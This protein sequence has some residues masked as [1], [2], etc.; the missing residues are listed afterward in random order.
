M[1]DYNWC[2]GVVNKLLE[3]NGA[4]RV[5]L[6]FLNK[7]QQDLVFLLQFSSKGFYFFKKLA[8]SKLF[9]EAYELNSNMINW[10]AVREWSWEQF[11]TCFVENEAF[12]DM[13]PAESN[14]LTKWFSAIIIKDA[15]P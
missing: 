3:S 14:L 11:F 15:A 1:Y 5:F 8:S 6:A 12:K 7:T 10:S 13:S 4:Y 9:R 2:V